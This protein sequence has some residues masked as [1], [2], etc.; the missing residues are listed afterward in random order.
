MRHLYLSL[1]PLSLLSS[2]LEVINIT[3]DSE[4]SQSIKED[5]NSD[6]AELLSSK[7]TDIE[8][9][10]N[11]SIGSD[12]V[13]RGF[14]R[15]N[16][17]ITIDDAKVCGACPNRMDPPSMH[18]SMAQ[19]EDIEITRGGFDVR[20]FGSLGGA[21]NV[22]TKEP[23]SGFGGSIDGGFGSFGAHKGSVVLEGGDENIRALFGYSYDKAK[24]YKDGDGKLLS[25]QTNALSAT[26]A[27][28]YKKTNQNAYERNSYW[29]KIVADLSNNQSLSIG[30]FGDRARDILYPRFRMDSLIDDTDSFNLK[31]EALNLG[32]FSKKLSLKAY[33][34]KVKHLMSNEFR[35]GSMIMD[36]PITATIYG[37]TI[38]NSLDIAG[39]DTAFGLDTSRRNWDG[40]RG[41]R[42]N[43]AANFLIPDVDTD[44]VAL[45]AIATYSIASNSITAGVRADKSKIK[46]KKLATNSKNYSAL[47]GYFSLAH[48]LSESDKISIGLAHSARVPDAKELYWS[49]GGNENLSQVKNR[50]LDIS[51][52]KSGDSYLFKAS[53]FYSD[54]ADYIYQHRDTPTTTTWSNID[55]KI[56]GFSL[57]LD[58]FFSDDFYIES[59]ISNQIGKKK[60]KIANQNSLNLA[61]I[62]PL[63][64]NLSIIKDIKNHHLEASLKAASKPKIDRDNGE[65]DLAGYATLDLKYGYDFSKNI[66]LFAGVNNL[67]N[68][69]YA[70]SNSY[71]GNELIAGSGDPLVLNE[72]GRN[73]YINV[74]YKF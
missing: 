62:P 3:A 5:K 51:Y 34:S 8:L 48:S 20:K 67:F 39:V 58:W 61:E 17:N 38:E 69:T 16:I 35:S 21:I 29:A 52:E 36:A 55:A 24:E 26:D 7:T 13:L 2:E 14:R 73:Y 74:G 45:F 15:D 12:V 37:A 10:R 59:S 4:I 50:E 43:P 66:Y 40:T 11:S 68:K 56:Y 49:S 64:M 71:I 32:D 42:A 70:L 22:T 46:A 60:R 28:K 54:L 57:G 18:I 9:V 63:K 44:N 53:G 23:R 65:R 72:M 47:S 25:E 19:I 31:Y 1:L 27:Q 30:Y 41:S 6:L 33:H